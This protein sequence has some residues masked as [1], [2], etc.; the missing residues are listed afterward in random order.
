MT[1]GTFEKVS[2]S[3]KPLY[4]PRMLLLCGFGPDIQP[5]FL[6]V[7]EMAGLSGIHSVWL[8]ADQRHLRLSEVV[9]LEDGTG[10]GEDSHL[11][12]GIIVSGILEKE[13]HH[14][15]RVSKE[16][17]MQ[18]ALWAVLTPVSETWKLKDLLDELEKEREAIR[19]ARGQGK[20]QPFAK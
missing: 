8:T 1:N 2:S 7:L 16:A 4:G 17:G 6:K 19:R 14:L 15:M 12:R 20:G 13:L 11:P 5:N 18:N 9:K 10:R 3:E